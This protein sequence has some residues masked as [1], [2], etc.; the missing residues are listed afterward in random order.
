MSLGMNNVESLAYLP[1]QTTMKRMIRKA[2]QKAINPPP[3]PDNKF[4]SEVP[5]SFIGYF[6]KNYIGKPFGR[7]KVRKEPRFPITFWNCYDRLQRLEP[8]TNN[9]IEVL[10]TITSHKFIKPDMTTDSGGSG[11]DVLDNDRLTP[12]PALDNDLLT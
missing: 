12:D 10:L 8:R 1:D 11:L 9:E 7:K 4:E 6:E 5:D 2:R 3:N